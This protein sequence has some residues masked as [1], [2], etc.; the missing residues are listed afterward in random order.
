MGCGV[1]ERSALEAADECCLETWDSKV[2]VATPV[3]LG[4]KMRQEENELISAK[5]LASDRVS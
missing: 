2:G 3:S 1:L 4:E 5:H